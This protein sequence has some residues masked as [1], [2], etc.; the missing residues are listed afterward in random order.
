MVQQQMV[1]TLGY[2]FKVFTHLRDVDGRQT[3]TF[4]FYSLYRISFTYHFYV[5]HVVQLN[6]SIPD[7]ILL[8]THDFHDSSNTC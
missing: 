6:V 3:G 4:M 8:I 7:F 5:I 1:S 2:Y